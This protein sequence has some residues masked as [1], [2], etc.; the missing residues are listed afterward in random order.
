M[1]FNH[2]FYFTLESSACHFSLP[3]WECLTSGYY[4]KNACSIF[5][6]SAKHF[7]KV[8]S[9][10]PTAIRRTDSLAQPRTKFTPSPAR[11]KS[12]H[13]APPPAIKAT[14]ILDF[15]SADD[16]F[17]DSMLIYYHPHPKIYIQLF[18]Q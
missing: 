3:C 15:Q 1:L 14:P 9:F 6:V 5:G 17:S 8:A 18:P 4:R 10:A 7:H 2:L 12:P 11:S 13:T 16:F